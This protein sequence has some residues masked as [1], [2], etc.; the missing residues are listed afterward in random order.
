MTSP[1]AFDPRA[2]VAGIADTLSPLIRRLVAPNPSPFTFSG[3]CTYI[4]GDNDLVIIDPGPDTPAHADRL[5]ALIGTS[6][7]AAILVT[8]THKD[9]S[10][11]AKILK[12]ETGATIL[13]CGP[14]EAARALKEGEFNPLDSSSDYD[15]VPDRI[16]SD[17]DRFSIA[18]LEWDVVATPG[19]TINHLSFALKNER[20]LFS[21]D[22][23]MGW[24]TSIVAP[25]DGAMSHY[26]RSLEKLMA[27]D[28]VTYLPG[29]GEIV[30]DPQRFV[31]HLLAHRRM[32]E[33]TIL[34]AVRTGVRTIPELVGK[35]YRDL[36]PRLNHAAALS[37]F[38]HLEDLEQRGLIG[39]DEPLTIGSQFYPA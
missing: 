4:V 27:R 28:D 38:A 6:R 39:A 34:D 10:P 3:T 2:P 25:P 15:Y 13:G 7:L 32:R 12:A 18:A 37:V 19:H 9:H 16:L 33:A 21:G 24:S 17:G 8:H 26:M 30:K 35:L 20:A 29:H 11:L 14:H 31:S 5:R 22:H 36:D 23:V 1:L